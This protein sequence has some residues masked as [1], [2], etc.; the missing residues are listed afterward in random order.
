MKYIKKK[1][2]E[3]KNKYDEMYFSI[4]DS[5]LDKRLITF[6]FRYCPLLKKCYIE[7]FYYKW[8]LTCLEKISIMLGIEI[9][10]FGI[11]LVPNLNLDETS[12]EEFCNKMYELI[13][14]IRDEGEKDNKIEK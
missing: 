12:F 4:K 7:S 8:N 6:R 9:S 10:E 2:Y 1:L 11:L 14:Q 13:V 5:I 3:R